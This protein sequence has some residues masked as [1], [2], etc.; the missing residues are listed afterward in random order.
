[1]AQHRRRLRPLKQT[2][3]GGPFMRPAARCRGGDRASRPP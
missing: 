1:M 3:S 2:R